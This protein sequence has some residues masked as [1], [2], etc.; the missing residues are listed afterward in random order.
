MRDN[1][2]MTTYRHEHVD[3]VEIV[4]KSDPKN[5]ISVWLGRT[6]YQGMLAAV[7]ESTSAKEQVSAL[8]DLIDLHLSGQGTQDGIALLIHEPRPEA[9]AALEVL[10]DS[11]TV[12]VPVHL[13]KYD[14]RGWVPLT[15][16]GFDPAA[17]H[18]HYP[19]W[20]GLLGADF[21]VP[22]TVTNLVRE[23]GLPE[24]RA[25]PQLTAKG[26]WSIRVE[27]LQVGR[28]FADGTGWLDVGKLGKL[29]KTGAERKTWLQVSPS[30][31]LLFDTATVAGAADKIREFAARWKDKAGGEQNEHV[32]ES[33]ILRGEIDV[34][35]GGRRLELIRHDDSIV[36]WGSQ[37]PTKWGPGR[38]ARY[39]D[40]L[41][42]DPVDRKVPWAI[43]MKVR[44]GEGQYYRHAVAQA[45]L[46]RHFIR[47]AKELHFWF[48]HYDLDATLCRAAVVVPEF[49][50]AA[51]QSRL[52]AL[53]EAFDVTLVTVPEPAT[54]R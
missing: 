7:V 49:K 40:A 32:L 17:A 51:W 11:V 21:T 5:S 47:K 30:G 53:C 14:D 50:T 34:T 45:V 31:R 16:S 43:E 4:H 54:L 18:L 36:N 52:T 28:A 33:R 48:E 6:R 35:I 20:P 1:R 9:A 37:F 10:R 13:L 44:L 25:Y 23:V 26:E 41:L 22:A 3:G 29:G 46:Y 42:R 12:D 2:P 39:L 38:P 24:V 19:R 15:P 8:L 27:G